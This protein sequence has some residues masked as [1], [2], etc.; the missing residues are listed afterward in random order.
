MDSED[1]LVLSSDELVV[2][3]ACGRSFAPFPKGKKT[4][5]RKCVKSFK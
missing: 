4:S 3:K 2:K 1:N 5:S